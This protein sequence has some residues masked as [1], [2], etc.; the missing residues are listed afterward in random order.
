VG[1]AEYHTELIE[2]PV[3]RLLDPDGGYKLVGGD[4]LTM[5][6]YWRPG[7]AYEG[8]ESCHRL[9]PGVYC[10][11]LEAAL[12]NIEMWCILP[13]HFDGKGSEVRDPSGG[14]FDEQHSLNI[15]GPHDWTRFA[16]TFN[17]PQGAE[18]TRILLMPQDKVY[19]SK[20]SCFRVRE[21]ALSRIV[22]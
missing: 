2:K 13:R 9:E 3:W 20:V 5:G 12:E 11:E 19:F 4:V 21:A 8:F 22:L 15:P 10:V 1:D 18:E 16:F 14:Y 7:Q 17:V 6:A